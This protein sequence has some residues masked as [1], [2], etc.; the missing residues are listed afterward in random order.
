MCIRDRPRHGV[1]PGERREGDQGDPQGQRAVG[2]DRPA[3]GL[4]LIHIFRTERSYLYL[5]LNVLSYTVVVNY[6]NCQNTRYNHYK[7]LIM[8]SLIHIFYFMKADDE[9]IFVLSS[10]IPEKTNEQDENETIE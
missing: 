10:D 1:Y 4:S 9:D 5:V 2:S 3:R 6:T 8:L 7:I